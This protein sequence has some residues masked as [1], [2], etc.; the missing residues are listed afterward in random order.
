MGTTDIELLNTILTNTLEYSEKLRKLASMEYDLETTKKLEDFHQYRK[1]QVEELLDHIK[2]S[3]GK[4]HS[5][6]PRTEQQALSWCPIHLPESKE[7]I[8][9]LKFLIFAEK[10]SLK[11]YKRL[12]KIIEHDEIKAQLQKPITQGENTLKYLETALQSNQ[13]SKEK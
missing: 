13:I 9:L 4:A 2:K 12:S 1:N 10:N 3:G 7:I 8:P 5:T 6:P 11:D